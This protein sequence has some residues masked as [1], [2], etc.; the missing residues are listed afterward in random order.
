MAKYFGKIG[1]GQTKD[2]GHSVYDM[3][4]EERDVYGDFLQT[5]KS[6]VTAA[7]INDDISISNRISIYQNSFVMNNI[8]EIKYITYA[9]AKWKVSTVELNYPRIILTTGG[10]YNE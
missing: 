2:V 9:G 6:Q 5:P 1:I 10:L 7:G 4:I 3:V 8:H